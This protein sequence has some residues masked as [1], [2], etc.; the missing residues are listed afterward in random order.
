[1]RKKYVTTKKECQEQID[2]NNKVCSRCGRKL[3][4]LETVNNAGEPTFWIGCMHGDDS[5]GAWGHFDSGVSKETFELACKYVL[6]GETPCGSLDKYEYKNSVE[7]R[8]YWF[9]EQ[10]NSACRIILTLKSLQKREPCS[11]TLNDLFHVSEPTSPAQ[12]K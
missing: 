12:E 11:T 5:K 9:M 1:M 10:V 8:E 2:R 3:V 6:D 7:Q 4:P